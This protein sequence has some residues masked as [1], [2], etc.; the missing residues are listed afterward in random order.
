MNSIHDVIRRPL[1]SEKG[2][3]LNETENK[4]LMEVARN[5]NKIEIK[6]AVEKIFKVNVASVHTVNVHGKKKRL[7]RHEG[8]ARSWKKAIVTIKRG[9]KLDFLEGVK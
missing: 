6:Q 2:N 5:A 1:L 7:G 3:L 4:V 9:E 8:R